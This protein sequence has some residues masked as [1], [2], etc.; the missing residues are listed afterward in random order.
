[1]S[2]YDPKARPPESEEEKQER[3]RRD[4][5]ADL[6]RIRA[7][8][9]LHFKPDTRPCEVCGEVNWQLSEELIQ[10]TYID[11]LFSAR[12][13][14]AFPCIPVVCRT[15]GKTHLFNTFILRAGGSG[16]E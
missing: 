16:G 15:C 4:R 11:Q 6:E 7:A 2:D 13:L 12:G 10:L 1:M 8:L 14:V 3:L 5:T 9:D